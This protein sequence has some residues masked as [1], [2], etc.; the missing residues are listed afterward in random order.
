M[1]DEQLAEIEARLAEGYPRGTDTPTDYPTYLEDV[2]AL[3]DEVK[4]QRELSAKAVQL[5]IE[6]GEILGQSDD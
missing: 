5:G 1:T 4:R 6:L 2:R 3:L